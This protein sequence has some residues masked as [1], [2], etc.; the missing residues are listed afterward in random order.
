MSRRA[1]V[2]SDSRAAMLR[3]TAGFL[4]PL[5]IAT[6]L[7]TLV[8]SGVDW[9]H[10]Y[11]ILLLFVSTAAML[12]GILYI[13]CRGALRITGRGKFLCAGS[14]AWVV[15]GGLCLILLLPGFG[16]FKQLLLA[17]RAFVADPVIAGIERATLGVSAWRV[18]HAL[19]GGFWPTLVIDR[20]YSF[21]SLIF[22]AFPMAVPFLVRDD[23]RRAQMLI[24][25]VLGWLLI[26]MLAAW[27]FASA[28]PCYYNEL[29][30]AD[31]D[32]AALTARLGEL[33][34]QGRAAGLELSNLDFQSMLLSAQAS[35]RY[36][37]A[38]GISAMPS[39]HVAMA[40]LIALAGWTA[41]RSV[42]QVLTVYAVVIWI[43]SVHLGW[44]Y[45]ADGV[46]AAAMMLGVWRLSGRIAETIG[47]PPQR[48][49]MPEAF[50]A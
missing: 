34:A 16:A 12:G 8:A 1:S 2:T 18:T 44:H 19:F 48:L 33:A 35:G 4:L 15:L 26:G 27:A 49:A 17:E 23:R 28:G 38:G 50:A 46:V 36:A 47:R 29:V 22:M 43:A 37:P 31:P 7:A 5:M 45:A 3:N 21:W 14:A 40:T 41:R 30:G 24:A 25:W 6:S 20:I 42:G 13:I 11:P 10:F 9:R 32:F 39:M